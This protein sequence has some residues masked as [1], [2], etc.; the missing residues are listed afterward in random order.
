MRAAWWWI[1]RWRKS[2]AYTDMS[3]AEQGAYRNLLD[4]LWLRDG[5]LP[6][7]ERILAKSAGDAR[8]WGDVREAVMA[9]FYSTETG[10]RNKT[11]DRI[12]AESRRRAERQRR[13]REAR[14]GGDEHGEH[15][16]HDRNVT[17]NVMHNVTGNVTHNVAPSPSPSPSQDQSPSPKRR[18]APYGAL[19]IRFWSAYPRKIGKRA[20]WQVWRRL[21]CG[22]IAEQIIAAV[23]RAKRSEAWTKDG[24]AYIP[25][26]RTWLNQGR[27]EDEIDDAPLGRPAIPARSPRAGHKRG[28]RWLQGRIEYYWQPGGALVSRDTHERGPWEPV[29]EC[30]CG[31]L[32]QEPADIEAGRCRACR[33]SDT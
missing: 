23:E 29:A 19:F 15:D 7:S 31:R 4:E 24:G 13:Y 2:T 12:M 10:Y 5:V 6:L 32:L 11:H 20:A 16:E 9:R 14:R 26:P 33:E 17:R 25:H 27:W 18:C 22:S 21:K 30:D 8:A 28:E 3:L 1:D